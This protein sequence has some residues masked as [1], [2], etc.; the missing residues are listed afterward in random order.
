MSVGPSGSP[1][2]AEPVVKLLKPGEKLGAPDQNRAFD[3]AMAC[4]G[5]DIG[6]PLGKQLFIWG[7]S[8]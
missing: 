7:K 5:F 2:F 4:P 3:R 1:V 6:V 8:S